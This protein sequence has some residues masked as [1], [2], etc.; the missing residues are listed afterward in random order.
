VFRYL[1]VGPGSNLTRA[2]V[3]TAMAHASTSSA[4][5]K[6]SISNFE[7]VKEAFDGTDYER[8]LHRSRLL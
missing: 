7:L 2:Q 5:H 6:D 1:G 4:H 3:E 8:L